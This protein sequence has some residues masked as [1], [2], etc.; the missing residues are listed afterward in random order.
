MPTL[1]EKNIVMEVKRDPEHVARAVAGACSSRSRRPISRFPEVA[2][3]FSRTGTPELAADPMPP[4]A[5]DTFII[6]KPQKRVAR[7]RP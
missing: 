7:S 4:N 5:S 3:V 1:D 6:L 2:F